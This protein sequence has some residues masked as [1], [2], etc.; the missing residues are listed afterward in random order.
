MIE[1]LAGKKAV[2][3]AAGETVEAWATE[4]NSHEPGRQ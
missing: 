3:T 1:A 2:G 4:W